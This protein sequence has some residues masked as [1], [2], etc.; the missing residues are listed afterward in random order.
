[1]TLILIGKDTKQ[2]QLARLQYVG[3]LSGAKCPKP[4]SEGTVGV[5]RK[6]AK[7][8]QTGASEECRQN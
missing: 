2:S 7:Q 4:G 8:S 6:N 3:E 5:I 1:M